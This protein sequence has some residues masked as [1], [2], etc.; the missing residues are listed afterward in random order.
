M[1]VTTVITGLA[2]EEWADYAEAEAEE[3]EEPEEPE[4]DTSSV[5]ALE[6]ELP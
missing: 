3:P 5:A 6:S 2:E 4:P 1:S